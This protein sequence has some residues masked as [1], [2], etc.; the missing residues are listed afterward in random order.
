MFPQC[1][2][3]H[4]GMMVVVGES[5]RSFHLC[6]NLVTRSFDWKFPVSNLL[7]VQ[8]KV[9][10]SF[11]HI[12]TSFLLLLSFPLSL[13]PTSCHIITEWK[14][15]TLSLSPSLPLALSLV[16][17]HTSGVCVF[18][19]LLVLLKCEICWRRHQMLISPLSRLRRRRRFVLWVAK[20]DHRLNASLLF[21]APRVPFD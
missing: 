8:I 21:N 14:L 13:T 15:W 10:T 19:K 5:G 6:F 12:F 4:R 3:P 20:C 7:F 1:L 9:L 18:Q 2:N 16:E 11:W 17:E